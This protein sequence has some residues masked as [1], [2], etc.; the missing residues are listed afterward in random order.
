L[1]LIGVKETPLAEKDRKRQGA[2]GK[3]QPYHRGTKGRKKTVG[4]VEVER[5]VEGGMTKF[6]V[7]LRF[8]GRGAGKK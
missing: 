5:E 4:G 1:N 7:F 8:V 3:D 2:R 6:L